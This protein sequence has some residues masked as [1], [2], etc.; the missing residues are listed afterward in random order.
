MSWQRLPTQIKQIAQ[1]ELSARQLRVL[2]DTLNGHSTLTIARSLGI[3]E[4]TAR[5]HLER[6][7]AKMAPHLQGK[8]A[9]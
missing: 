9:A 2:Q 1:T 5:M 8:D 7:L 3:A 4:P 6:A